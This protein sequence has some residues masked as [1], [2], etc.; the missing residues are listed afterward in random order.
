[1][2]G[3]NF[4]WLAVCVLSPDWLYRIQGECDFF[5]AL[6]WSR[7]VWGDCGPCSEFASYT[8]AFDLQL[9]KITENLS[10]ARRMALGWSA[11]KAN[12]LVEFALRAMASTGL[13]FH[14]ALG[15]RVRWRCQPSVSLSICRV[16]VLRVSPHQLTL[17]QSS[18]SGLWCCRQRA[19]NP[20]PSVSGCYLRT[21]GTSSKANT[22]GL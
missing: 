2:G 9:R 13:L 10:Q 5:Q 21:R 3:I 4:A 7:V 12:C 1:M 6:R 16:A 8:L 17:S 19:E 22:H 11:P 14:A 15:F 18:R 20:D